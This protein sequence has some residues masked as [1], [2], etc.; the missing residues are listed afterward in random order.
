MILES[1]NL[2]SKQVIEHRNRVR[3]VY[4]TEEGK[5]ELFNLLYDCGVFS[6]LGADRLSTRN[7]A[8]KKLQEMGLLDEAVLR[9]ILS[10][11]LDSNPQTDELARLRKSMESNANFPYGKAEDGSVE[12]YIDG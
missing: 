6:E 4:S 5:K 2:L 11:W 1:Q 3:S 12:G 7:F 10:D 9:R 8:I